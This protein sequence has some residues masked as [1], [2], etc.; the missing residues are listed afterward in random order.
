[1]AVTGRLALLAALGALVVGFLLPSVWGVLVVS[2]VLAVLAVA[3]ALAAVPVRALH[4]D[5][6]Q[7][8]DRV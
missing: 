4:L 3:D 1:M 6:E 7:D 2:A 5:R 8:P